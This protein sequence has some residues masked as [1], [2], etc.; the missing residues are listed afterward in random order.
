MKLLKSPQLGYYDQGIAD[1]AHAQMLPFWV[2]SPEGLS[3]AYEL[4]RSGTLASPVVGIYFIRFITNEGDT[5]DIPLSGS[6]VSAA[7]RISFE[8]SLNDLVRNLGPEYDS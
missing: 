7:S 5:L 4:A 8:Y 2:L 6:P 1:A 3:R